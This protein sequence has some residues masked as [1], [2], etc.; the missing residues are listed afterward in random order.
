MTIIHP[1]LTHR[2]ALASLAAAFCLAPA[3]IAQDDAMPDSPDQP[4]DSAPMPPQQNQIDLG[5]LSYS[6][7]FQIGSQIARQGANL[8]T[9]QLAAGVADAAGGSQPQ[10]E[11]GRMAGYML[12]YQR[13]L[14]QR[15][16]QVLQQQIAQAEE[17]GDESRRAFLEERLS[18]TEDA[19][20]R[21]AQLV[22][23]GQAGQQFLA[24]NAQREGVQTT[25]SGLQY[26][27][28]QEGEGDAPGSGDTVVVHYQGTFIDGEEFDSSYARG[29]P[30]T[31]TLGPGN[32]IQGWT[33]GLQ[34][35]KPGGKIKLF[36]PPNL[37]YGSQGKGSV[38]P[39]ATLIFEVELLEVNP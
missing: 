27:I 29:E 26:E 1:S 22:R 32:V 11:P 2:L 36:V 38:P 12:V 17:A 6:L 21:Q 23:N 33:E 34:L 24:E 28:L 4:V 8:D 16:Q 25:E 35:V 31:F 5:E 10:I 39:N 19:L 7:G 14:L 13:G 9:E 15:Q 20:D 18:Q 3:A 30:A 37:A